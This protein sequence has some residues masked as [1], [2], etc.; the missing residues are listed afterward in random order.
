M[1]APRCFQGPLIVLP[2]LE[3]LRFLRGLVLLL[4]LLGLLLLGHRLLTPLL[5]KVGA[6]RQAFRLS[7]FFWCILA[8]SLGFCI[9]YDLDYLLIYQDSSINF[10][11]PCPVSSI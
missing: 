8:R 3:I 10:L 11:A 4:L 6:Q 7:F 2:C 9:A 1:R 5:P